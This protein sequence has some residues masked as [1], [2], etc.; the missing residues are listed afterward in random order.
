MSLSEANRA[1]VV[2]ALSPG[3]AN[4]FLERAPLAYLERVLNEAKSPARVDRRHAFVPH[5]KHRWFCDHCGYGPSERLMH[6]GP[7]E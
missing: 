2:G 6:K 5:K 1:Y 7:D 4:S 3:E